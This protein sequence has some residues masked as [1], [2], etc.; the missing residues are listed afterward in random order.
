[1]IP[2]YIDKLVEDK[3]RYKELSYISMYRAKE[4]TYSRAVNKYTDLINNLNWGDKNAYIKRNNT[5]L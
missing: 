1:M 2:K 4:F 5:S 3:D